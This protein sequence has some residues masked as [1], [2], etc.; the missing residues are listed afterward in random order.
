MENQQFIQEEEIDLRK[1]L[2]VIIKRRTL[3]LSVFFITVI[4]AAAVNLFMPKIYEITSTIQL[5]SIVEP[6]I[7]KDEAVEIILNKNSF[8]SLI[9]ELNL[10]DE[11]EI[12]K[13]NIKID[14]V[15]GTNLLMI[16]I[17]YPDINVALQ[18]IDAIL[19]PLMTQ[20]HA[21]FQNRMGIIEGRL[22]ELS[23]ATKNAEL[24]IERTQSLIANIPSSKDISQAELS[25]RMIILQN[26][27]PKYENNL[28][29]L[30]NQRDALQ[31]L[32][33]NSKDFMVF[34]SPIRP[35]HPVAPKKKQN[36]I[37]AGIF[38]LMFG[39]FLAFFLEFWQKNN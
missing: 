20:D 8:S 3:I 36:V 21:I 7:N 14:D 12:L 5:A 29:D 18:I 26:T 19:N 9:K 2:D 38:G 16:K 35:K 37:I 10:K 34:D 28:T 4:I 30:R 15:K 13:K 11:V 24:D 1:Y 23:V 6:L 33:V 39:I 22:K 32:V 25:L 31:L 17:D 27:L